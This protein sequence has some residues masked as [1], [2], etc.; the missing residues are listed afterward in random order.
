MRY[1]CAFALTLWACHSTSEPNPPTG[2]PLVVN[3]AATSP[4]TSSEGTAGTPDPAVAEL[5]E[6]RCSA[7]LRC[8]DGR[9]C[10]NLQA[11]DVE[12][13]RCQSES[14]C[15]VCFKPGKTEAD[16]SCPAGTRIT[17]PFDGVPTWHCSAE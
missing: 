2:Q 15:A 9:S 17:S 8:P 4:P 3:D 11:F 7:E 14:A 6:D 5:V 1:S 12:G 10:V 16:I 13:A